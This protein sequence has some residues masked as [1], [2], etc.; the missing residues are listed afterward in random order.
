MRAGADGFS[1]AGERGVEK[2]TGTEAARVV[3]GRV[4]AD[5]FIGKEAAA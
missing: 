2:V 3:S 4:R 5:T 1:E